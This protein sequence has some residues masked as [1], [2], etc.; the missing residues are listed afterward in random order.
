MRGE[1][2]AELIAPANALLAC[3][4]EGSIIGCFVPAAF[5]FVTIGKR[6]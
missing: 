6:E 1:M 5:M 4:L 3:K 2:G